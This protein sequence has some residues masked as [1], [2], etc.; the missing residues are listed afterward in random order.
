MTTAPVLLRLTFYVC[1]TL[2][3][4]ALLFKSFYIELGFDAAYHATIAK[5]VASGYGWAT[6]YE[7]RFPFN[8][9]VTT[10][11]T[12][13]LPAAMIIYL[14]GNA[15]WVPALTAALVNLLIFLLILFLSRRYFEKAPQYDL[16]ALS[17]L[18][19]FS[20][21][22]HSWWLAFTADMTVCLLAL[23]VCL[24]YV[25]A[26]VAE[27][28]RKR[29]GYALLTG[30][31][32]GLALLAK[33]TAGFLLA[34]LLAHL[35]VRSLSSRSFSV[36]YLIC[37]L[38]PLLV[39]IMP[40]QIISELK[41]GQLPESQRME[42]MEYKQS[43][44]SRQGTGFHEL[45]ESNHPLKTVWQNVFRN[46]S[47]LNQHFFS[48]YYIPF[49]GIGLLLLAAWSANNFRQWS[50]VSRK[51]QLITVLCLVLLANLMWFLLISY[52]WRAK[53]AMLSMVIALFLL[54]Y[55][56]AYSKRQKWIFVLMVIVLLIAPMHQKH[57]LLSLYGF[58]NTPSAYN[59]NLL[60]ARQ[61]FL[62]QKPDQ[63]W[64]GCGWVFAP[65]ALEYLLPE[66][67]N[68]RD[69]RRILKESGGL[70]RPPVQF[71]LAVNKLYWQSSAYK[72]QYL[73]VLRACSANPWLDLDYYG[74]YRCVWGDRE[75]R[76]VD[77]RA[78]LESDDG[79]FI[80]KPD[81]LYQ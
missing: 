64:A 19:A 1:L 78:V 54:M 55:L 44:F 48:R 76:A 30:A 68:F 66:A 3:C 59:Q 73:G 24:A 49:A 41:I 58:S 51:S 81:S 56:I 15:L 50:P 9:D 80:H 79:F 45:S 35:V 12:L 11:P 5:N 31:L 69:C 36:R 32:S 40:W 27:S 13:I 18:G 6:S 7:N 25:E 23:A 57:Y 2:Y 71:T 29:A 74:V 17:L 60:Q 28:D 72:D 16:F 62:E 26:C 70:G 20:L 4:S 52:A 75:K 39:L 34:G 67:Q 46:L 61:V 65:W 47:I 38:L 22:E 43:F 21:I 33:A 37:F 8:P 14:V 77:V 53:H 42:V 63:P 10:G